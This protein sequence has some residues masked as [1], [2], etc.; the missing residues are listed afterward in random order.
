VSAQA[1]LAVRKAATA[2]LV[3]LQ[4]TQVPAIGTLPPVEASRVIPVLLTSVPRA[5]LYTRTDSF[6]EMVQVSPRVE[7]RRL[8]LAV[9]LQVD[10]KS[11]EGS[12]DQLDVWA[13]QVEDAVIR[14]EGQ[15]AVF[16][17]AGLGGEDRIE[18]I[19]YADS[20]ATGGQEGQRTLTG[21]VIGFD[22]L[23]LHQPGDR[24]GL[25]DFDTLKMDA[26]APGHAQPPATDEGDTQSQL[27][28]SV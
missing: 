19:L 3:K 10:A 23:Y 5:L 2:E 6:V 21:I 4:A 18:R 13:W 27:D 16:T 22:V 1:R 25:A 9:E 17:A 26:N 7:R 20:D 8:R 15:D 11:G 14:L 12:Q 24:T 28:V